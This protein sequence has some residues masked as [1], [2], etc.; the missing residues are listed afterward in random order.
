MKILMLCYEFPPLG[1]GASRV[2]H[3]LS[4]KLVTL[5]H[6]VDLVTM[7]YRGLP[8]REHVNGVQVYRVPCLRMRKYACTV[9]EAVSYLVSALPKVRQL[10]TQQRYDINHTHFIL[11][12]GLIAWQIKRYA[13]LP[14]VIT[15]HGS[16][17]PGYNPHR[18]KVAH[19]LLA[20]L[21]KTITRNAE[22][23]ISPSK[24]LQS[25][26]VKRIADTKVALI[27]YGF[28][29]D[30]FQPHANKQRRILVV[31]RMVQRKG[32][33]YLLNALEVLP[34]DHEIHIVGDGPYLSNLR[35]MAN[36][37]GLN[38]MFWGW[39]DNRSSEL[40]ELYETS[41]IFVL[42]SEAENFPVSLMEAMA[43]GLAIITTKGTGC[44]EVVGDA[45][46]LVEPR[47]PEA[48]QAAL[49]TLTVD[50]NL[51]M[52]LGQAARKRLEDNFSWDVVARRY[53]DQ[54]ERYIDG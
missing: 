5:G 52:R 23:I 42:P 51:C 36:N 21:W 16:D 41:S 46:I 40:K 31:T 25:L 49:E 28:D 6:Q 37:T 19:K 3:G 26:L 38:L 43:A 32:V 27:P 48:I 22:Q 4:T 53:L 24:T 39:L 2:A 44:A 45:A 9:P 10:V 18:V 50:D 14:Y 8:S 33:Q 34:L 35:K 29:L 20:P 11:P 47:N 54:Y 12:D 13:Q 1:G 17:V 30:K 15:A 7:G